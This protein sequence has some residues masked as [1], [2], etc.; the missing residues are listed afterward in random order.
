[1]VANRFDNRS[2]D[3][4]KKDIKFAT[5]LEKHFFY[6]WIDRILDDPHIDVTSWDNNGCDNSGEFIASGNTA[7]ADYRISG[8]LNYPDMPFKKVMKDWPIE[9][10]WVPTAGKLTL[11]KHDLKAYVEEEASILFIYNSVRCNTDLRK[12]KDYNF[13]N[14]IKLLKSKGQQFKWGIMWNWQVA[15]FYDWLQSNDLFKPISYMGGKQGY[16]LMQKDFGKWFKEH[17]W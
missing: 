14:H 9:V 10:K 2:V 5:M 4:F 11:K 7:G 17:N 1:M 15:R 8:T 6:E 13:E 16:A 3:T 12:P